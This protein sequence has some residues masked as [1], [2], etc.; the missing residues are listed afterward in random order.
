MQVK[1]HKNYTL[2][3]IGKKTVQEVI[4]TI[5]ASKELSNEHLIVNYSQKDNITVKELLLHL[6]LA[7]EKKK[8]GTSFVVVYSEVDIDEISDT[9]NVVPTIEEAL[10]ILEM[11]AIERDLGF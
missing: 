2:L 10:D 1:K 7:E 5:L 3:T 6:H 9:L 4:A 11:E 8:H